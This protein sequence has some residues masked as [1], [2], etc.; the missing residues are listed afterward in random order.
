MNSGPVPQRVVVPLFNQRPSGLWVPTDLAGFVPEATDLPH[1]LIADQARVLATVQAGP[2]WQDQVGTFLT[3]EEL[4]LP[5]ASATSVIRVISQLPTEALIRAV[6]FMLRS[7]EG[8]QFDASAQ[9]T[10]LSEFIP[11]GPFKKRLR[12]ALAQHA[13][14][15]PLSEQGLLILARLALLHGGPERPA[16]P[17]DE[18]PFL[19]LLFAVPSVLL[20]VGP[21]NEVADSGPVEERFLR[22]FV[23]SG[24]LVQNE[25]LTATIA[26]AHVMYSL[27]ASTPEAIAHD[28]Y[29]PFDEWLGE[30]SGLTV[31]DLQAGGFG[32]AAMS[33]L[34]DY[35]QIGPVAVLSGVLRG[36]ALAGSEDALRKALVANRAWYVG[37]FEQHDDPVHIARDFRAFFERP[38]V[39]MADGAALPLSPRAVSQALGDHGLYRRLRGLADERGEWRRFTRFNGW[40]T[41]QYAVWLTKRAFPTSGP[42]AAR[43]ITGFGEQAY[44]V[45]KTDR[46]SP[47]I[48]IDC[49]GLDLILVEVAS[50]RLTDPSIIAGD[51]DQISVDLARK[52]TRKIRQLYD[53][54]DE[55]LDRRFSY[56]GVRSDEL[57]NIWPVLV[58]SDALFQTEILWGY[59]DRALG[60]RRRDPR[61]RP[62]TLLTLGEYERFLGLAQ[63]RWPADIVKAKTHPDWARRD[64]GAWSQDGLDHRPDDDHQAVIKPVWDEAAQQML[65]TLWPGGPPPGGRSTPGGC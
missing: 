52:L 21:E 55:L 30:E 10:M 15:I 8:I 2:R 11:D 65:K 1:D 26:R 32:M 48:A 45:G 24:G 5:P 46:L 39:R 62:L 34:W 43:R 4:G 14:S 3:V 20:E 61:V 57:E 44:M 16:T 13:G 25:L 58:R 19:W 49:G 33:Q 27:L 60:S 17:A 59:I 40:L 64:F 7:L 41:E 36:T 9:E 22:M 38:F 12:T 51:A 35:D 37:H 53:R 6:A 63:S 18:E 50:G 42:G 28:S 29:C 56:P 54:I 47:D 23:A 31:S